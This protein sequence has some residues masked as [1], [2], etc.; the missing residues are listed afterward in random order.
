MKKIYFFLLIILSSCEKEVISDEYKIKI[1]SN[2]PQFGTAI[3]VYQV[4]S[5]KDSLR[6]NFPPDEFELKF[7]TKGPIQVDLKLKPETKKSLHLHLYKNKDLIQY[8]SAYDS[9]EAAKI[10]GKF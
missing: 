7:V 2:S 6:I 8:S 4:G 9:K 10:N 3:L 5:Q 1:F